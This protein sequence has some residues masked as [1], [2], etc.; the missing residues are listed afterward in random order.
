MNLLHGLTHTHTQIESY[1]L[2]RRHLPPEHAERSHQSGAEPAGS[3]LRS[4]APSDK[5]PGVTEIGVRSE[6]FSPGRAPTQEL[7]PPWLWRSISK[8]CARS[9]SHTLPERL[10]PPT[11]VGA[12]AAADY[13]WQSHLVP[14][15]RL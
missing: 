4:E 3:W 6:G 9:L 7:S 10:S 14:H 5:D 2:F 12:V 11:S 8:V 13:A 1:A 15:A